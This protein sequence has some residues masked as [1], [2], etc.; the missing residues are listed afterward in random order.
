MLV[1]RLEH[2]FTHGLSQERL[3]AIHQCTTRIN[4]S[5]DKR[6]IEMAAIVVPVADLHGTTNVRAKMSQLV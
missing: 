2:T 5:A 3:T 4:I 1:K 6:E